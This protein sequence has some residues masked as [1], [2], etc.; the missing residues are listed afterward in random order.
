VCMC[1]CMFVVPNE[2]HEHTRT[3]TIFMSDQA[4]DGRGYHGGPTLPIRNRSALVK[5]GR[6]DY[7]SKT[8]FH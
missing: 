1:S 4:G 3:H 6:F 7:P 5:I 8:R 2:N